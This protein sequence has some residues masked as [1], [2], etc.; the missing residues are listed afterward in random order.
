MCDLYRLTHSADEV[1][2]YF[3]AIAQDIHWAARR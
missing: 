2:K 3:V 1:A